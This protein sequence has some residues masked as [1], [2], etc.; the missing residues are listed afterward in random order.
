MTG[1]T[2]KDDRG[3]SVVKPITALFRQIS[4]T[5]VCCA[6]FAVPVY[7]RDGYDQG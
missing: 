7:E 5:S 6:V 1:A 4:P 2:V 3:T